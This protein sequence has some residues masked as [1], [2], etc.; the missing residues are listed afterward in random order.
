MFACFKSLAERRLFP[1]CSWHR[2]CGPALPLVIFPLD[3]LVLASSRLFPLLLPLKGKNSL[4]RFWF[5]TIGRLS[6]QSIQTMTPTNISKQHWMRIL[7]CMQLGQYLNL[8][9]VWARLASLYES[10]QNGYSVTD[11]YTEGISGHLLFILNRFN[12]TAEAVW[13]ELKLFIGRM[14]TKCSNKDGWS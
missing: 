11:F 4:L 6:E 1:N 2:S 5:R 3:G 7:Y 14:D 8:G 10:Q 13:E 9:G 12:T